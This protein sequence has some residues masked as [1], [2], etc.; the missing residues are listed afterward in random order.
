MNQIENRMIQRNL[1]IHVWLCLKKNKISQS[2]IFF[3][4]GLLRTLLIGWSSPKYADLQF[5]FSPGPACCWHPP[6][7]FPSKHNQPAHW[8]LGVVST[9]WLFGRF[10]KAKKKGKKKVQCCY[11]SRTPPIR[12][13]CLDE[14]WFVPCWAKSVPCKR[15]FVKVLSWKRSGLD[16]HMLLANKHRQDLRRTTYAA[17]YCNVCY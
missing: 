4:V 9:W 11:I 1:S 3:H 17:I 6:R 12:K 7:P 5:G 2:H 13:K 14:F 10:R 8:K 15:N 16:K